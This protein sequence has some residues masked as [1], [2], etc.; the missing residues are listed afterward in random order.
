LAFLFDLFAEPTGQG[1][2]ANASDAETGNNGR[3]QRDLPCG[4]Q[5]TPGSQIEGI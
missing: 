3:H 4:E 5:R 2:E 1:L